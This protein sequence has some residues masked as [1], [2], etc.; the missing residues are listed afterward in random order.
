MSVK[1]I[2]R[3]TVTNMIGLLEQLEELEG[4]VGNDPEGCDQIRNLKADLITT[5]QKYECMVREISEQ[6]GVYQDLYG[7]I[8]FRFVPEKLKLLR[9]TIPQDSYEFVLLKASIQKSHMI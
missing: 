7:K 4:M 5:Y 3:A 1:G 9:R 6:V 8:R 2:N